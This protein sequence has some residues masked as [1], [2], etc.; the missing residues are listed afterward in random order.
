[1]A[2]GW[3]LTH[4]GIGWSTH[5]LGWSLATKQDNIQYAWYASNKLQEKTSKFQNTCPS[6]PLHLPVVHG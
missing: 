4:R 1:M 5:E 6:A 3:L 2:N